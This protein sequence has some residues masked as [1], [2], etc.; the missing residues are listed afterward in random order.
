MAG[1]AA[2]ITAASSVGNV[3][4]GGLIDERCNNRN[5]KM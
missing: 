5:G 1:G 2:G 4:G 3:K